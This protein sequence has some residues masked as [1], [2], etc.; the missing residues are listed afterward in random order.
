MKKKLFAVILLCLLAVLLVA[1]GTNPPEE[2]KH[3]NLAETKYEPDCSLE[4]YIQ[5]VC[6][7]CGHTY[8][9]DYVEP[10]GHKLTATVTEPTCEKEGYSTY[11]CS[12]CEYSYDTAHTKPTGHTLT[13]K[14]TEQTCT[15]EG[16]TTYS[17]PCGY[18]YNTKFVMPNGHNLTKTVVPPTCT[19]DG[20]DQLTCKNCAYTSKTNFTSRAHTLKETTVENTC[21]TEGYTLREC[22]ACDY[23]YKTDYIKPTG[24]TP[25]PKQTVPPTFNMTGYTVYT[26]DCGYSYKSDYVW[27][28][29]IFSGVDGNLTSVFSR[30]VDLSYHNGTVDFAALANDGADF[31]ILRV[32]Y[33]KNGKANKDE[34][35]EEYYAAAR[36]AG[37]DIGAYVYSYDTSA[38]TLRKN[39]AEMLKA[40]EGKT[41]EYPIYLDI[42]DATQKVLSEKTLMN[43]CNTY[44]ELLVENKY[45]PG[46]YSYLSFVES[47]LDTEKLANHFEV[48]V[49]HYNESLEKTYYIGQYNMWQY[50]ED[51]SIDGVSG[52][53]DLN[54]CYKNYPSI[55]KSYGYNGYTK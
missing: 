11:T 52:E 23:S 54:V 7:D 22:E 39:T 16:Y 35:F 25:V 13:S 40:L 31:V 45:Y 43:I 49:A 47:K 27:Y 19:A 53:V 12:V 6:L 32:G 4:G 51:G 44:C 21:T 37:L 33:L 55:I 48:W 29:N 8:K 46:I 5:H 42:E 38:D 34:K 15:E 30:G 2:C 20:Y 14:R 17:C 24:H 1:C 41:F 18:S 36:K 3:K 26:C 10:L 9:S 28:S 50:T